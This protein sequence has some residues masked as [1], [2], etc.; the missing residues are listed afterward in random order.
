MI[1][2]AEVGLERAE[3]YEFAQEKVNSLGS[4]GGGKS[5]EMAGTGQCRVNCLN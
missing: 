1:K 4:S 5:A 3:S 2:L